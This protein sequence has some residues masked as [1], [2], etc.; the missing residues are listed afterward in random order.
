MH[1]TSSANLYVAYANTGIIG[2]TSAKVARTFEFCKLFSFIVSS[3]ILIFFA[4]VKRN[5]YYND[6]YQ[7]RQ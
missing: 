6:K 1:Q 7:D 2:V 4:F 5:K 3:I